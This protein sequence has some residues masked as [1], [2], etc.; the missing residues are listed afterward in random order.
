MNF[1]NKESTKVW[2]SRLSQCQSPSL[3]RTYK[4][5]LS[6]EENVRLNTL[7]F[8]RDKRS[9]LISRALIRTLLSHHTGIEPSEL[10]FGT[11][12]YGKPYLT[13]PKLSSGSIHFNL[14]HTADLAIACVSFGNMVGIDTEATLGAPPLEI[15]REHFTQGEVLELM[16]C[17][18][19]ARFDH[20]W[21]V[22]TL[23]ECCTKATGIGL[24]TP[25]NQLSFSLLRQG[26]IQLL[27]KPVSPFFEKPW[28]FA[29]WRPTPNHMAALCL[30]WDE[31]TE[32]LVNV[33]EC[34]VV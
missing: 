23:K 14:S 30:E 28:W 1:S 18:P 2:V 25:L 27:T 15:M 5:L 22:W 6:A 34:V 7:V 26:E 29:Q 24:S 33:Y 31:R 12:K 11:G 4:N 8:E 20:F 9:Y 32:P 3:L 19:G 16:A 17:A 21:A 10:K 13:H